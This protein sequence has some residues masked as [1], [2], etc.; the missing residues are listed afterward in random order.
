MSSSYALH[1]EAYAD[2]EEIRDYIA[3]DNPQAANRVIDEIF[4]AFRALAAFPQRGFK[5]PE[6]T[7]RPLRFAVVRS[8][9]IAYAANESPLW[10]IAVIHGR[11]SPRTIASI[12]GGRVD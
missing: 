4:E 9:V 12:L 1:P 3:Q 8:Y 7:L 5:R 2:L 11:R 6:L 10:I